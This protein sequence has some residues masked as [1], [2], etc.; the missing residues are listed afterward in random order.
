MVGEP[1]FLHVQSKGKLCKEMLLAWL[2]KVNNL[3][4]K[5]F[6]FFF[7]CPTMASK[8]FAVHCLSVCKKIMYTQYYSVFR[9][10]VGAEGSNI[11]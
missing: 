10:L 9:L 1:S 7:K 8:M 11:N 3:M 2:Y 6:L 5:P 4:T